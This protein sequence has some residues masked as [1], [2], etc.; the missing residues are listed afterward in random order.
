MTLFDYRDGLDFYEEL[1]PFLASQSRTSRIYA[2]GV[3][4]V[5][6]S[7]L[8]HFL[9]KFKRKGCASPRSFPVRQSDGA[10]PRQ[11]APYADSQELINALAGMMV[12]IGGLNGISERKD[13]P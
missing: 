8:L 11:E 4:I 2:T 7:G 13:Y 10:K 1:R 5:T 6:D 9:G 3:A 12:S